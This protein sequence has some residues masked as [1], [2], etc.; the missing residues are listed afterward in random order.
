MISEMHLIAAEAYARL[1]NTIKAKSVLNALQRAR[2][3]SV[4]GGSLQEVKAEWFKEMVGA[5]HYFL[6]AKRWGDGFPARTLQAGTENIC[7]TG[8]SYDERVLPATDKAFNW[9]IPSY[10]IKITPELG[11]NDGYSEE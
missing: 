4:T 8:A 5:G 3:A 7:M 9:P 6:C 11:Q 10:E 2:N 1:E